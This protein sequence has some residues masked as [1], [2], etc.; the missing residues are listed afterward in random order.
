MNNG[1]I[2]VRRAR[3]RILE[4]EVWFLS[5][6]AF[7]GTMITLLEVTTVHRAVA[8]TAGVAV[9]SLLLSPV[10]SARAEAAGEPLPSRA[11]LILA[12]ALGLTLT[13]LL[14][15]AGDLLLRP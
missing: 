4:A 3:Y 1:T 7:A 5:V 8:L 11:R 2:N 10:I 15:L 14:G 9:S 13:L 6:I 12:W